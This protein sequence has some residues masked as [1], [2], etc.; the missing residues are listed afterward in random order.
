VGLTGSGSKGIMVK[1]VMVYIKVVFKP[2]SASHT[3]PKLSRE[4]KEENMYIKK[5]KKGI[6][7]RDKHIQSEASNNI[8]SGIKS[9]KTQGLYHKSIF[10]RFSRTQFLC[11]DNYTLTIPLR[12]GVT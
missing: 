1:A 11:E 10:L 3:T 4:A 12:N 2:S 5:S 8:E 6:K 9:P 7:T